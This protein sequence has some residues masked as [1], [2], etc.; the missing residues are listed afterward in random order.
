MSRSDPDPRWGELLAVLYRQRIPLF[1]GGVAG[2]V[3][4]VM[5]YLLWPRSWAIEVGLV[6]HT[7]PALELQF[8]PGSSLLRN[9]DIGRMFARPEAFS[10]EAYP[11]LLQHPEVLR[12]IARDTVPDWMGRPGLLGARLVAY[13][14]DDPERWM[15][16]VLERMRE[17]LR[18]WRDARTGLL[19]V[20][21]ETHDPELSLQLARS[22]L[23]HFRDF[24]ERLRT[25]REVENVAFLRARLAEAAMA[26][27]EAENALAAFVDRNP[28][29][30]TARYAVERQRLE[31]QV[32]LRTELYAELQ[33]Q[34]ALA[35]LELERR[36]PV[37]LELDSLRVPV[38]PAFP[39]PLPW[40]GLGGGGLLLLLFLLVFLWDRWRY[41]TDAL[42][43]IAVHRVQVT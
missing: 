40:F 4:L 16:R 5:S 43:E 7:E 1:W 11:T 20:R 30:T 39:R 37:V 25:G 35:E 9:L 17:S 8:G 10:V 13:S 33:R 19:Y 36:R 22:L 26:L 6:P 18:A 31:R 28:D 24:V 3:L 27:R 34:L 2:I 12:A 41:G 21:V 14:G 15:E 38:R 32:A 29:A 23:R 42:Q